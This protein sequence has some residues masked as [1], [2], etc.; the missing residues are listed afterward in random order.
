M[1]HSFLFMLVHIT[2]I[3]KRKGHFMLFSAKKHVKALSS[4]LLVMISLLAFVS[5]A[6]ASVITVKKDG[7]GDYTVIQ[8]AIN[9]ASSSCDTIL[10]Y[11]GTYEENIV[12]NS[13]T[14]TILA[15]DG[16]ENTIIAGAATTGIAVKFQSSS[17]S[18]FNGFTITDSNVF[19]MYIQHS[20]PTVVN[21][22]FSG[23]IL[24][25]LIASGSSSPT[26]KNCIIE[27][28]TPNYS[29]SSGGI[30]VESLSS[31]LI[32]DCTIRNNSKAYYGGGVSVVGSSATIRNCTINNN[33]AALGGGIYVGGNGNA[34][35]ENCNIS[36]NNTPYNWGGGIALDWVSSQAQVINCTIV[37]NHSGGGGGIAAPYTTNISVVN[38]IIW[39]NT[40][41]YGV[42]IYPSSLNVT[43]SDVQDGYTGTG[44]IDS[45][46]SFVGSGDYH[47]TSSSP[48]ID[49]G[50]TTGA[51]SDDIDGDTRD[52]YPDMGADE[53]VAP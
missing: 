13:K 18:I 10:V 44:N 46:P 2:I 28:N 52:S 6:A 37:N 30:S 50:T 17:D 48:C 12:I 15:V 33:S 8:D 20:S 43:Y 4:L 42:Q 51:P 40:G 38:S 32:E 3:I 1:H 19:G 24:N 25:I 47:L 9:A 16:P 7:T 22:V 41:S 53:Y 34:I 39:G 11:R 45:D 27:D 21:C 49:Q 23:N 36:D 31:A 14:I 35:I 26:I 29:Y 5:V